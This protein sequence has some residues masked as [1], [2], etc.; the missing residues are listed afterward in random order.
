MPLISDYE[1]GTYSSNML[2]K[3]RKS[4][5][6]STVPIENIHID[7]ES[8]ITLSGFEAL[9]ETFHELKTSIPETSGTKTMYIWEILDPRS[10]DELDASIL[11]HYIG[12]MGYRIY[13][14][15]VYDSLGASLKVWLWEE[16]TDLVYP[17]EA[18][19]DADDENA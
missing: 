12:V 8:G 17:L 7:F 6:P 14:K 16:D 10:E 4:L 18:E 3:L 15:T 9:R 5:L 2:E 1:K 13:T 19:V 11:Q